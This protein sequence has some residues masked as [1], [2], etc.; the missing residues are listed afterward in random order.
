MRGH[1][2]YMR[3]L[4]GPCAFV[5]PVW[6]PLKRKKR[7]FRDVSTLSGT[8]HSEVSPAM[9]STLSLRVLVCCCLTAAMAKS[10]RETWQ[11]L[12]VD[13]LLHCSCVYGGECHMNNV[14]YMRLA[15]LRACS[16]SNFA[17]RWR[18]AACAL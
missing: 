11:I 6:R 4:E 16:Y 12:R 9:P 10:A 17:P 3:L 18:F 1:V 8:F 7:A 5:M 2:A 14:G 15:K 13:C